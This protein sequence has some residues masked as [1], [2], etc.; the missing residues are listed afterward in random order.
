MPKDTN[1]ALERAQE[2]ISI[3]NEYKQAPT[4]TT[5]QERSPSLLTIYAVGALLFM[6]VAITFLYIRFKQ[7]I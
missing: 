1:E 3:L 2:N 7:S 6:V 4:S 5:S